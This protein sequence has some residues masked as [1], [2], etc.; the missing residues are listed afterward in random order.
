MERQG[1][2]YKYNCAYITLNSVS[3]IYIETV[4]PEADVAYL[5]LESALHRHSA[6][7]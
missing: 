2:E 6:V 1:K 3:V 5:I 7:P 4:M